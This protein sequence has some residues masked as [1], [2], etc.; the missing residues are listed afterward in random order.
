MQSTECQRFLVHKPF[1]GSTYLEL[2]YQ[3]RYDCFQRT[4]VR[5]SLTYS[6][7]T[8]SS[9]PLYWTYSAQNRIPYLSDVMSEKQEKHFA[10]QLTSIMTARW[11]SSQQLTNFS[12]RSSRIGLFWNWKIDEIFNSKFFYKIFPNNRKRKKM[13]KMTHP[14][15]VTSRARCFSIRNWQQQAT[16]NRNSR[17]VSLV[18]KLRTFEVFIIVHYITKFFTFDCR[19]R[20]TVETLRCLFFRSIYRR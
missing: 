20:P 16:R 18:V 4:S 9:K 10:P 11:R 2:W 6:S 3:L 15:A 12:L 8:T 5:L 7:S 14:R 13:N 19:Y 17:L 1:H